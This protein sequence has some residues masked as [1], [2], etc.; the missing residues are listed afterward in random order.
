MRPD[1]QRGGGVP[2]SAVGVPLA[3]WQGP[4]LRGDVPAERLQ[5]RQVRKTE[6]RDRDRDKDKERAGSGGGRIERSVIAQ[7]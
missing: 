1:R 5:M 7:K 3:P 6:T 2:A 4:S